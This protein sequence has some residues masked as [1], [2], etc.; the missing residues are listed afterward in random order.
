MLQQRRR[1]QHALSV[2][3]RVRRYSNTAAVG[4]ERARVRARNEN[5]R[6][7]DLGPLDLRGVGGGR[8]NPFATTTRKA[9]ICIPPANP[10]TGNR[11]ERGKM[12]QW[13]KILPINFGCIEKEKRNCMDGLIVVLVC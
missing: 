7:F 6:T 4:K 9:P 12:G 11:E 10:R 5:Y 3:L 1:G 8:R 13:R 2:A